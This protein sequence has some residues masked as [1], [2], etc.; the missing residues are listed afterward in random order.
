MALSKNCFHGGPQSVSAHRTGPGWIKMGLFDSLLCLSL[1]L[2]LSVCTFCYAR[3]FKCPHKPNQARLPL[4]NCTVAHPKHNRR[5]T[6]TK[7][8]S[9]DRSSLIFSLSLSQS[10]TCSHTP[11]CSSLEKQK[12][13]Q[14]SAVHCYENPFYLVK[15]RL[16]RQSKQTSSTLLICNVPVKTFSPLWLQ[17]APSSSGLTCHQ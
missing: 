7:Q 15:F 13:L 5:Q 6:N 8:I 4:I 3:P 14:C 10:L 2:S 9:R 1:S 12:F 11:A 16:A 17:T